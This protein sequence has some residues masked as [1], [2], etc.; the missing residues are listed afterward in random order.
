[1]L[2]FAILFEIFILLVL[3]T[4]LQMAKDWA[5]ETRLKVEDFVD[6]TSEALQS[7]R[8]DL[9]QLNKKLNFIKRIQ[10][11]SFIKIFMKS[12]DVVNLLLFLMPFKNKAPVIKRLFSIRL[13]KLIADAIK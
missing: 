3:C 9:V 10:K 6:E 12:L 11:T 2:E 7:L 13:L 8:M 1:M 5:Y 4:L